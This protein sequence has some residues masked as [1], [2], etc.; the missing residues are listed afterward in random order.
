M[1]T[2]VP[3]IS[4]DDDNIFD[5]GNDTGLP[6]NVTLIEVDP[7][8]PINTKP[9]VFPG[10]F[11]KYDYEYAKFS[12]GVD[13]VKI[14]PVI[15]HNENGPAYKSPLKEIWAKDGKLHRL[16]GPAMT[17][18]VIDEGDP[19]N[20]PGG[21]DTWSGYFIEGQHYSKEQFDTIVSNIDPENMGEILDN[22]DLF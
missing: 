18:T 10:D 15:L 2:Y 5:S 20:G 3:V 21:F 17:Q 4:K 8:I 11:S 12:S 19:E 6:P 7:K 16:D 22:N 13:E 14:L 9:G 1:E